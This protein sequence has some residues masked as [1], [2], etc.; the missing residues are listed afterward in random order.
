[1]TST[2]A[3]LFKNKLTDLASEPVGP[4]RKFFTA[5]NKFD[6]EPKLLQLAESE[7]E[8]ESES[9]ESSEDEEAPRDEVTVLWRVAPDFGEL[10]D[11]IMPREQDIASGVKFS[12]W[13]N[14]LGWS[15]TGADDD[16][17]VLQTGSKLRYEES[18]FDTPADTGLDDELILNM[19]QIHDDLDVTNLETDSQIEEA[20]SAASTAMSKVQADTMFGDETV[21]Y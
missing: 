2:Q 17:V 18:G 19:V 15:D 14:P 21:V 3:K 12:G 9:D 5:Y 8:S 16:Q 10:D 4:S 1:M 11:H 7:S 20:E 13:T 6:K